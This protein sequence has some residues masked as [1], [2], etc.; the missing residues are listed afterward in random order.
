[1][2]RGCERRRGDVKKKG[3]KRSG[4]HR[5]FCYIQGTTKRL[6]SQSLSRCEFSNHGRMS[7]R[8]PPA[9]CHVCVPRD[10]LVSHAYGGDVVRTVSPLLLLLLR[11]R[12]RRRR[13]IEACLFRPY[14]LPPP[15]TGFPRRILTLPEKNMGGGGGGRR[16]GYKFFTT[17]PPPSAYGRFASIH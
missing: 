6:Q 3:T 15:L 17:P 13:N 12:R 10:S 5:R 4:I 14:F 8:T 2:G 16:K 7:R 9:S 1:M 11:R